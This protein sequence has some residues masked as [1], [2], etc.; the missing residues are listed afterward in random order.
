MDGHFGL[1]FEATR[2]HWVS[3]DECE[4]KRSVTGHDVGDVRMEQAVDGTAYQAV[5]KVVERALVLLEV[6]GAQS[7]TDHHVVAIEDLIHHGGCGVGW[8]G[9][10]AV[11]HDVHVGIDVFEH[12]ANHVA[13]ALPG[14]LADDCALGCRYFGGAVGGVVVVYVD[15][16]VRQR[17]FEVTH[18]LADG[19]FL[20]IARK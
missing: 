17:G 14:L 8:V 10:I 19:D 4:R 13:L 2:K 5:A 15:V 20:V 6:R 12:G 1:N 16:G 18:H 11:G 3:L 9:V 7:I